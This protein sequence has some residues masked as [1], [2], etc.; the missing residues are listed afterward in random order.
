MD[1]DNLEE[2]MEWEGEDWA[3][4]EDIPTPVYQTWRY[5]LTAEG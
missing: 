3:W 1:W 5:D 2:E 4:E